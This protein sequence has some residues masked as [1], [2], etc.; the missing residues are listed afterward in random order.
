VIRRR[1]HPPFQCSSAS[2]KFLNGW[3]DQVSAAI[4]KFQCSSASR[5]FLNVQ[6][7]LLAQI[8]IVG[9]SALQRAENSSSCDTADDPTAGG[10]SVLFSEPKIPQT[11]D[12]SG[13]GDPGSVSVLFSEPKIPQCMA[14]FLLAQMAVRVS[15]LFSEPKIPQFVDWL[16]GIV[17]YTVS[18]LFSEPKIPQAS[19]PV[20]YGT[21]GVRFSALQRAEN[22]SI[23]AIGV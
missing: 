23:C 6:Q 5:K 17:D 8:A 12:G 2:R 19:M 7:A 20:V 21:A 11:P 22:S 1:H 16:G 18:V 9:F 3:F 10:V 4:H 13:C 15:V 14:C